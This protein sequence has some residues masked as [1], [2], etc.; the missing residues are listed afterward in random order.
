MTNPRTLT[1][2]QN[3]NTAY[4]VAIDG[5]VV[6]YTQRKTKAALLKIAQR[7]SKMILAKLGETD[8]EAKYSKGRWDFG[9]VTVAFTG[10]TE[11]AA[12]SAAGLV[13]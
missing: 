1:E 3:Y 6:A 10:R 4:E 11:R 8:P 2:M 9:P 5:I 7:N 12:A 13:A